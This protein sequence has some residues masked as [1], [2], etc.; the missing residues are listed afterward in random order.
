[1]KNVVTVTSRQVL[2]PVNEKKT[3]TSALRTIQIELFELY[4]VEN[5]E[6]TA[7]NIR[8]IS[9][10]H[11]EDDQSATTNIRTMLTSHF[12]SDLPL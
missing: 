11:L 12:E 8:S 2:M 10:S 3:S 6:L 5:D 1:M 9:I 4:H 7:A